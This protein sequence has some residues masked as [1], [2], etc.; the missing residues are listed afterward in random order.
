MS[1]FHIFTVQFDNALGKLT[2]AS[3][4]NPRQI[5]DVKRDSTSDKDDVKGRE[6]QRFKQ[7][8]LDIE[9]VRQLD[10][11]YYFILENI[12]VEKVLQRHFW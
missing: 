5:I 6:V 8:Q 11:R 2:A 7:L 1:I 10:L 3:V 9:Q 12:S 4:H